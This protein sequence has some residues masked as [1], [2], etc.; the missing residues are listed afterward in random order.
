MGPETRTQ[1]LVNWTRT[2]NLVRR[3]YKRRGVIYKLPPRPAFFTASSLKFQVP[4]RQVIAVAAFTCCYHRED[5]HLSNFKLRG[6]HPSLETECSPDDVRFL[7]FWC[8]MIVKF[9]VVVI[10]PETPTCFWASLRSASAAFQTVD[11]ILY[12][13]STTE[14][15]ADALVKR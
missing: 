14:I 13:M 9:S 2:Q 6:N 8:Y 10:E 15:S 5:N 11:S 4:N 1:N 7:T 3:G 12:L